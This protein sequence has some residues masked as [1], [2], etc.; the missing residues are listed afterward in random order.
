MGCVHCDNLGE[1]CNFF[2]LMRR[3]GISPE[4]ACNFFW[5]V[6]RDVI[7]PEEASSLLSSMLWQH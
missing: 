2:W 4:E 6:R 1:V 3:D 5:L 7:S